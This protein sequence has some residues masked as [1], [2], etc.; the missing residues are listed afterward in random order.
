[1]PNVSNTI[2]EDPMEHFNKESCKDLRDKIMMHIADLAAAEGIAIQYRGGR[3]TSTTFTMKFEAIL[4]NSS[5]VLL[6]K[7]RENFTRY[8]PLSGIQAQYLD[9]EIVHLGETYII[10]GWNPKS[11]KYPVLVKEKKSGQQYKMNAKMISQI[12][13][14]KPPVHSTLTRTRTKK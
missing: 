9:S 13:G 12:I 3:F 5:G 1:L 4:K 6:S 10:I 14:D 11:R 2:K 7:E 8:A